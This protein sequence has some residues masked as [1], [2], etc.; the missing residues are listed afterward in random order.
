MFE[1]LA[2]TKELE[3]PLHMTCPVAV[4]ARYEEINDATSPRRS[5][6]TAAILPRDRLPFSRYEAVKERAR[7]TSASVVEVDHFNAKQMRNDGPGRT[8]NCTVVHAVTNGL[9][10]APVR[11]RGVTRDAPVS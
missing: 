7:A 8:H 10:M 11:A 2:L 9:K 4:Q 3:L 1:E 6:R 5:R